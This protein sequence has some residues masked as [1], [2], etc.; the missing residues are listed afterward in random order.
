M[1]LLLFIYFYL[2]E[3]I[4]LIL[5]KKSII[6]FSFFACYMC[7]VTFVMLYKKNKNCVGRQTAQ[8]FFLLGICILMYLTDE[9][10]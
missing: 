6:N 7:H 8:L 1:F 5:N 10:A 3:Y 9:V 4:F 2:Y